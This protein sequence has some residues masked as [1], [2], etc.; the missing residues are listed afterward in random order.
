M[1][2]P[3]TS[4]NPLSPSQTLVDGRVPQRYSAARRYVLLLIFCLAQFLDSINNSALFS[5]IP[6]LENSLGITE[7][8]STWVISAFQLTFA[9]F[10]LISGRISDVYNPKIAFTGGVAALGVISVGAGFAKDKIVIIVL[11]AL[12]GIA[13]AMT[14]PSALALLVNVFVEPNEQA[15]ALGLFGGCGAVANVL[16]LIIGGIF[17][18]FASWSWV[19]WFVAIVA[20]FVTGMCL[21]FV[22]SQEPKVRLAS[23]GPRWRSL[24]L[25]GVSILTAALILF[26]FAITSGSADGWATAA[27]LVPLVVSILMVVAF[28]WY[29]TRIPPET[30]AVPPQTWFRPNFAVL[31]GTALLPYFWWTT[32]F[33]VFTLLWQDDYEWS[34]I[35]TAIHMIPIG[36]LS[37]AC[38]SR[39][40]SHA[41]STRSGSSCL[42]RASSVATI[43]LAF[44]DGPEKYWSFIFPAFI[45]GS[46]GASLTYTHTNIAIFR[47]SPS[48]MAGTVGAIFN[49][50]LQ[51]GSAV[52]IAAVDSL[53]DSIQ[54]SE[55]NTPYAGQRAAFWLLLGVVVAELVAM[56]V[57]YR[58]DR[59]L[60]GP[61]GLRV[62]GEAQGKGVAEGVDEKMRDVEGKL[63]DAEEG[64]RAGAAD[65]QGDP[66]QQGKLAV[67]MRA[68]RVMSGL[69]GMVEA[70][71]AHGHLGHESPGGPGSPVSPQTP[72]SD[73]TRV[74]FFAVDEEKRFTDGGGGDG[75]GKGE[76]DDLRKEAEVEER[77]VGN[78]P[79]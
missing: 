40:R 22:P 17:V 10:L 1:I 13:A 23:A 44:A 37:L 39:A 75:Y 30:A 41:R 59:E 73:V 68:G 26:I 34:A 32:I 38:L 3:P 5:A 76:D 25:V 66:E 79:V 78:S 27:V 64:L 52:G 56:A 9:S 31:F 12:S 4:S 29:E 6:D 77:R 28:F 51:L 48:S 49:G 21:L 20:A 55:P 58:T 53:E 46:G 36:V 61:Q 24:D 14:I 47:T 72:A 71:R 43:L 11:R 70:A 69:T 15:R 63:A 2:A 7:A 54:L 33:T 74:C 67:H 50:A 19:F 8:E 45:L 35:S 16:G 18:Q 42:A 60:R 65:V 57:F 62:A